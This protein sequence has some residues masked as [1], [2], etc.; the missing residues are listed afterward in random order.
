MYSANDSYPEF[1]RTT[2]QK[3]TENQRKNGKIFE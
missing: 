2:K 1:E 3:K